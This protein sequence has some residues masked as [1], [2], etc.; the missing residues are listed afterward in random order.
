MWGIFGQAEDLL[1]AVRWLVSYLV[2]DVIELV[3]FNIRYKTL[4]DFTCN[5]ELNVLVMLRWL[6]CDTH[7]RSITHLHCCFI[8]T[9][10]FNS[11][12][13]CSPVVT[14]SSTAAPRLSV[15]TARYCSWRSG[16]G[17]KFVSHPKVQTGCRTQPASYVIGTGVLNRGDSG[18]GMMLTIHLHLEPRRRMSAATT[19]LPLMPSWYGQDKLHHCAA[20]CALHVCNS[21][22]EGH[23]STAFKRPL[24]GFLRPKADLT[25][26]MT[27][28]IPWLTASVHYEALCLQNVIAAY[29]S[30]SAWFG[31]CPWVKFGL[32]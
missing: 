25:P 19:L 21:N 24:Y 7:S 29:G 14:W 22:V 16:R 18:W 17:T 5:S 26:M 30:P 6:A 11:T 8:S 3:T 1:H 10:H 2:S 23:K 9:A 13:R 4:Q 20:L 28:D 27:S 12:C 15:C 32:R 31:L